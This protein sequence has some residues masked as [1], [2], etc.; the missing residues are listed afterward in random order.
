[1]NWVF[2]APEKKGDNMKKLTD[3]VTKIEEFLLSAFVIGM[4]IDLVAG[5]IARC[6]FNNSL[7]FT[8]EIGIS[9][10]IG[11]TFLGIGYCAR[12]ATQ[13][14]MS[15]LYD[16]VPIKTKKVMQ[17]IIS[18]FTCIVML[19]LCYLSFRYVDSVRLL[20]RTTP[21]LR[22]PQWIIYMSLPIGFLLGAIESAKSF[23]INIKAPDEIWISSEFRLGEN[24]ENYDDEKTKEDKQ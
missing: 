18:L 15:V 14:S 4:A 12:K 10:N 19:A 6:V 1:M 7:T 5:V 3:I 23:V 16:L 21:A 11:V 9:F 17:Y 2:V 8:E 13:I 22:I 24:A 20:G